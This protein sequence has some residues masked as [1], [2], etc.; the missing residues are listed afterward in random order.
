ML[1][2]TDTSLRSV[3]V[4]IARGDRKLARGGGAGA[5]TWDVRGW[6]RADEMGAK[7]GTGGRFGQICRADH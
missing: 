3:R 7:L 1:V 6:C 5:I 2:D 4:S